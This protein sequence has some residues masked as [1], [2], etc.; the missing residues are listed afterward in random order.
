MVRLGTIAAL[1]LASACTSSRGLSGSIGV[2]GTFGGS[3]LN[4]VDVGGLASTGGTGRGVQA[5][6][7]VFAT[8]ESPACG[9][10][11]GTNVSRAN[12]TTFSLVVANTASGS[13]APPS[14]AAATYSVGFNTNPQGVQTSVQA[15]VTI[16]DATCMDPTGPTFANGGS[17]TFSS[18][19]S[20][21][22]AGTFD[23]TF[24][25]GDELK[26]SF[27][28]PVC[29]DIALGAEAGACHP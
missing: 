23:V 7:E 18:I 8:S 13:T 1:V 12:L 10:F 26:G 16:T 21:M 29:T 11:D 20:P 4:L 14:V 5:V 22:L 6:A 27:N 19:A 3:P 28:A 25:S 9:W 17:I 24:P 15:S 2:S